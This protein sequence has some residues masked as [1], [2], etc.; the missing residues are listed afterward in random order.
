MFADQ[1]Y[2]HPDRFQILTVHR[3][4]ELTTL[5]NDYK[6]TYKVGCA[7]YEFTRKEEKITENKVIIFEEKVLK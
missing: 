7:F 4:C 2:L 3:N 1:E 6:L 5:M